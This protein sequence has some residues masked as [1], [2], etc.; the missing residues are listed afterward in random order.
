MLVGRKH[1]AAYTFG[2]EQ[3]DMSVLHP[4]YKIHVEE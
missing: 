1:I 4:D 2:I 3:I